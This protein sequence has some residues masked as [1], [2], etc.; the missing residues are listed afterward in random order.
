MTEDRKQDI[1]RPRRQWFIAGGFGIAWLAIMLAGADSPPPRGFIVIVVGLM[2]LVVVLGL[3]LPSLWRVQGRRGWLRVV[4]I[5]TG[6]GACIGIG[7]AVLFALQGSGEPARPSPSA[8]D[9]TI[10]IVVVTVVGAVNGSLIGA[11]TVLCRPRIP[12]DD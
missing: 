12:L 9:I 10:W 4:W 2:A 3:S 5:C 1:A 8:E 11:V 6:L 7:L